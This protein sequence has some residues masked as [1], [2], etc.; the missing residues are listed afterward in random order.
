NINELKNQLE[1]LISN[2]QYNEALALVDEAIKLEP[3]DADLYSIKS[4]I[5]ISLEKFDNAEEVLNK[6]LAINPNHVDCL[7]N[8]AFVYEQ[9]NQ[10]GKAKELYEKILEITKEKELIF[11]IKHKLE[12]LES[13]KRKK[14][15]YLGWLGYNNIGD[16]VLYELFEKMFH[17][18]KTI[19][20]EVQIEP[21]NSSINQEMD[22][23]NYDL[24]VLGGGSL[25]NIPQLIDIC[26]KAI[27]QNIPVVSWGTGIDGFYKNN[28]IQSVATN[29]Q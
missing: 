27:K 1:M 19:S 26:S 6:G 24:I 4:V 7:Y 18:Y 21:L 28:H 13:G 20:E 2:L 8:K 15:L 14:I 23:S 3:K 12:K 16:D 11:E 10:I 25:F 29:H 22:L 5:L 9:K 17:K